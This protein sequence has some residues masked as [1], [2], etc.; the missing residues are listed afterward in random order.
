MDLL[1]GV[2]S[3]FE[4]EIDVV[5]FGFLLCLFRLRVSRL[6]TNIHANSGSEL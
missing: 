5:K 6:G 4:E 2:V 1:L 3:I